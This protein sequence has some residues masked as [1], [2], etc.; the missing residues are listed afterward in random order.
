MVNGYNGLGLYSLFRIIDS[1]SSEC[2]HIV[3]LQVG[4][5]DSKSMKGQEQL[6]KLKE[7]ILVDLQKYKYLAEKMGLT[8]SCMYSIGT[9]VVEEV[10]KMIPEITTT[11][12]GA[13]FIGGQLIFGGNTGLL[14]LLHNYTIFAIQRKLYRHGMTTIVIP[15]PLEIE[16]FKSK[17]N[18]KSLIQ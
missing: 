9:D 1:F 12:P 11:Y 15:I 2:Q 3:F 14:R 4:L 6:D 13:I 10:D 18:L 16:R 17:Q 7:N 8:A 5:V